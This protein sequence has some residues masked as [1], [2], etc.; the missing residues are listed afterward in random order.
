MFLN[1]T[2][3]VTF[4]YTIFIWQ[5]DVELGWPKVNWLNY[6]SHRFSAI[7]LEVIQ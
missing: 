7:F 2:N 4:L 1:D 3:T 6:K 5:F